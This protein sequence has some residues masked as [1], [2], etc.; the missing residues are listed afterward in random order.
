MGI[1][2]SCIGGL[3][4]KTKEQLTPNQHGDMYV[5]YTSEDF[6]LELTFELVNLPGNGVT[7][8][9]RHIGKYNV[10]INISHNDN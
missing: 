10:E 9:P 5:S 8:D 3:K 1:I 6:L 7:Y 2:P 4:Y